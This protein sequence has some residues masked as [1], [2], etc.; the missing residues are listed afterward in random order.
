MAIV[1][2]Y[3]DLTS[4]YSYL[5]STQI[6]RIVA[7]TGANFRWFPLVVADLFPAGANPLE[8]VSRQYDT[9][10]RREDAS[11]WAA[12]YKV[13]FVDPVDRLEADPY[14][15]LRAA[16]AAGPSERRIPLMQRIFK[17]VFVD[18][19][20]RIGLDDVMALALDVKL[21][22]WELR[23]AMSDPTNEAERLS[24]L[25]RAR[26]LGVFGAPFFVTKDHKFFGNDRLLLLTDYL[27][28]Q[29]TL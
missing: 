13:P 23:R 10:Y 25:E 21:D 27:L 6:D 17:A 4:P 28:E 8:G 29:P 18:L 26:A 19:R 24:I 2:A 7:G 11:A 16:I 14:L 15:L 3:L 20:T 9:E 5:A 12:H 1:E 22:P